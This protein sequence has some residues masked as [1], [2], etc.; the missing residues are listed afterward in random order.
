MKKV[1]STLI[2]LVYPFSSFAHNFRG[3]ASTSYD[4][5]DAG[6]YSSEGSLEVGL[7]WFFVIIVVSWIYSSN[8]EKKENEEKNNEEH[9]D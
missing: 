2:L 9:E 6:V 5:E 4:L 8:N 7:F 1:L 3:S